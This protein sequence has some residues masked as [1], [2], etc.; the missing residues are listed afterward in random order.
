[1]KFAYQ[2]QIKGEFLAIGEDSQIVD[3]LPIE[4]AI[5]LEQPALENLFQGLLHARDQF[6][7]RSGIGSVIGT[8]DGESPSAA[9][10]AVL[11]V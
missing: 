3:R 6:C 7:V 9:Q 4:G 8:A 11:P 5:T 2:I 10:E 1:M